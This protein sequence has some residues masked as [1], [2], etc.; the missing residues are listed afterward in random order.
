MRFLGLSSMIIACLLVPS[1]PAEA[2]FWS[3]TVNPVGKAIE[4][5]TQDTGKILDKS[6]KDVG[7]TIEKAVQDTGKTLEKAAEDIG[8]KVE[9]VLAARSTDSVLTQLTKLPLEKLYALKVSPDICAS[10]TI[11]CEVLSNDKV[12][13]LLDVEIDRR[14]AVLDSEDKS[15]AFLIS[16]GSL[17]V[18]CCAFGL[19]AFGL[20]RKPAALQT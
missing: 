14:K 12:R 19:S 11:S 8:V 3:G 13:P 5:A 2:D 16:L 20:I 1:L 15:R 9:R 6:G 7:K 4:K 18:S 10:G 17:V